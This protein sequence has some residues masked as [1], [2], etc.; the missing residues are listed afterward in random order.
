MMLFA[1]QTFKSDISSMC[2]DGAFSAQPSRDLN[3]VICEHLFRQGKLEVGEALVQ[4]RMCACVCVCMCVRACVRACV[5][6]C[7]C[8]CMDL[9]ECL[10]CDWGMSDV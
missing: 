8:A 4:V 2:V 6:V 1:V 10:V 3:L 5:C 9:S 7:V